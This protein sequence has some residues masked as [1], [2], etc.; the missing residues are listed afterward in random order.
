MDLF[1]DAN[2]AIQMKRGYRYVSV[3]KGLS[4]ANKTRPEV[5][6]EFMTVHGI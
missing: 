6:N 5:D 2:I 3:D 1:G 4:K